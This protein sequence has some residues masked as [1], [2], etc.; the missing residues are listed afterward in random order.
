MPK[1]DINQ[2]A[3]VM[4]RNKA[5]PALLRAVVEELNKLAMREEDEK[6]PPV[7]KQFCVLLSDPD[8]RMP[9]HDFVAWVLQI[10]EEESPVTTEDRILRAAYDF[11]ASKKGRLFPVKTIGEAVENVPAKHFKEV[12]A[13]VKTKTPVLVL[14]S[15]NIIPNQGQ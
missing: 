2:C 13:W 15:N 4:K 3:E 12:D 6:T 8:G 10:P 7:K 5:D 14:V 11:N 9:Q 1:V